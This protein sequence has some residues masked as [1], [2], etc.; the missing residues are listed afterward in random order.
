MPADS[1]RGS[2]YDDDSVLVAWRKCAMTEATPDPNRK[3]TFEERI[4][5]FGRE[6]GEAGERIGRQA[7]AAGKRLADDPGIKRAADTA[8]RVWGLLILLVGV[9]F[10]ADVTLGYEM[11]DVPWGDVWPIGLIA[12]GLVV[13]FRGMGR[14]RA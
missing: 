2:D 4:D 10:L 6:A 5:S 3:S 9:W 14:Q 13:V 7:E 11:P 8:A 12:I 1:S